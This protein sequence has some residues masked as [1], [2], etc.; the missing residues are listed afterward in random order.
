MDRFGL[1]AFS[2]IISTVI[3][4]ILLP[5]SFAEGIYFFLFLSSSI[6]LVFSIESLPTKEVIDNSIKAKIYREKR[7]N[8]F[9]VYMS[10]SLILTSFTFY[11]LAFVLNI[12]IPIVIFLCWTLMILLSFYAKMRQAFNIKLHV[13]ANLIKDEFKIYDLSLEKVALIVK[14]M[15][16]ND[17]RQLDSMGF[18]EVKMKSWKQRV[19]FYNSVYEKTYSSSEV[20]F[21]NAIT[22]KKR[23][24]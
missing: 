15:L 10:W 7:I 18:D 23:K 14:A 2:L 6:A 5:F 8:L 11:L 1:Y 13:I 22:R 21:L 20:S 17:S 16:I 9:G 19:S 4:I 3:F 12:V 24:N